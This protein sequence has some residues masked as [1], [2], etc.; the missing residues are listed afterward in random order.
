MLLELRS[1]P[2]EDVRSDRLLRN[3]AEGDGRAFERSY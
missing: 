1:D 3:A 2:P